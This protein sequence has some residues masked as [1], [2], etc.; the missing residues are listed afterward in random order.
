MLRVKIQ[1]ITTK[2]IPFPLL[3]SQRSLIP[4]HGIQQ[5]ILLNKGQQ[6][7]AQPREL[8]AECIDD[9]VGG[10]IVGDRR[11]GLAH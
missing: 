7:F 10:E 8:L 9:E 11:G 2:P 3:L 5:P 6:H 4:P 1:Q